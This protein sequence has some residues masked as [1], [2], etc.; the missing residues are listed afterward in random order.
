MNRLVAGVSPLSIQENVQLKP[1]TTFKIGGAARYFAE[2]RAP[3]HLREAVKIATAQKLPP[4]VLGSGSNMLVS[5]RGIEAMVLHPTYQGFRVIEDGQDEVLAEVGAGRCWDG[6]V[7]WAVENGYW[8]IE[9]LS[10]IPGQAGAALVQNIGAYG[11]QLSDVLV[12]AV[13]MDMGTIEPKRFDAKGCKLGYRTSI[14][15]T[16]DKGRWLIFILTLRLKKHGRPNLKYPDLASWFEGNPKPSLE[17]IRAAVTTIRDRKFPYPCEEKGGN[18]GSFFK[19]LMLNDVQYRKLQ[20]AVTKN[21]DAATLNQLHALRQRFT[22]G[23]AIRIPS[24]FLIEICGLKGFGVGGARVNE[25]QP[26]V[27]LNQGGATA[28]DVLSLARHIRQTVHQRTGMVLPLEPELVGFTLEE[29][30]S[31]M[32]LS[33]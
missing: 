20:L 18:A 5:D 22:S 19:N 31:T 3:G 23:S 17:D 33:S 9:N 8:G 25:S 1:Y 26:L 24:A 27:I 4:F 11:Q 13:V 12:N 14:F 7:K 21:F 16:T 28:D 30:R 6:V 32:A 15:N 29:V 10:H 2:V